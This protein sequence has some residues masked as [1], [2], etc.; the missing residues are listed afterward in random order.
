MAARTWRPGRTLGIFLIVIALM[1]GLSAI[2]GSWKPRL[3][4]DLAGGTMYT[5]VPYG[6]PSSDQLQNAVGIIRQRVNGNG[7]SEA[8]VS[9]TGSNVVVKIPGPLQA[10]ME[11]S[12]ARQAQMRF[13]IVAKCS[14][15]SNGMC[16][17]NGVPDTSPT[18]TKPSSS[19]TPSQGASKSPQANPSS[20]TS[21]SAKA[22][23]TPAGRPAF[24]GS[25]SKFFKHAPAKATPTPSA[26]PSVTIPLSASGTSPTGEDAGP[27][28]AAADLTW[29]TTPS[30]GWASA[31]ADAAICDPHAPGV[32][33]VLPFVNN[34]SP[35]AS[36]SDFATAY[37]AFLKQNSAALAKVKKDPKVLDTL[38][39][40]TPTDWAS[41]PLIG[42]DSQGLKYLLSPAAINGDQI[43]DASAGTAQ[44]SLSWVVNL[45]F[46][47]HGTSVFST[48][49]NEMV[50][51]GA[52]GG[53]DFAIVLDGSVLS[54]PGFTSAINN[55]QAQ[56]TGNFTADS[57]TQLANSLKFG[58]LPVKFDL[59]NSSV[60][61]ISAQLAGSQ[62]SAGI[63]AGV[64]GLLIVMIYCFL[65]YRGLGLVVVASLIIAAAVT[66]ATVLLLGKTAGFT[67]SLPGIAGMIVAVG[68]T[69][70]SFI[71]YFERIRD[72]M[73][74]GKSMRVAV[75]AGWVRARNTCLAA[76]TVSL[77]AAISLYLFAIDEI[78]GF[79]FALGI[80]TLIDLVV[81][82]W[83]T[84]PMISLLSHRPFFNDGHRLSGLSPE[85]LGIQRRR[86]L[87]RKV[88][89]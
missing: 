4:L 12:I 37:T 45:S 82:F 1:Y 36:E 25:D 79:A 51:G 81:F 41:R 67:L 27:Q 76:D 33:K 38:F 48:L 57:A 42:C 58:S 6:H 35:T 20:K 52:Y 16:M 7:V 73:R 85:S 62:L 10:N 86:G 50:S 44:N 75:Q 59:D 15:G 47:G 2:A 80:T 26:T 53:M 65:Y 39:T 68:I 17:T 30:T 22:T 32:A 8:Q 56:I 18:S 19:P 31:Y 66:Y 54:A 40:A 14:T 55:G 84:H 28:P 5:L 9:T 83:F 87:V 23:A 63:I 60:V 88:G 46:K 64:I 29:A 61:A 34:L 3:G 89:A 70:D 21:P 43:S 69:A 78:R 11:A 77:L 71:V 24:Y 74:D 13:R 72:E 49:S